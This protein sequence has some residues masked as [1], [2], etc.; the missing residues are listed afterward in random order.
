M[1]KKRDKKVEFGGEKETN[2]A[3]LIYSSCSI[4]LKYKGW[5]WHAEMYSSFPLTGWDSI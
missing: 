4:L 5:V 2:Q 3:A 1:F